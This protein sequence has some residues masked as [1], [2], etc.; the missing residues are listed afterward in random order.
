MRAAG[1]LRDSVRV[2]GVDREVRRASRDVARFRSA[3]PGD[4]VAV[5]DEPVHEWGADLAGADDD[6]VRL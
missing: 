3:Q 5:T 4:V 1:D 2:R 6:D